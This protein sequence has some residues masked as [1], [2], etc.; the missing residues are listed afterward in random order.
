MAVSPSPNPNLSP[1][2]N[3]NPPTSRSVHLVW[4]PSFSDRFTVAG[5]RRHTDGEL[6]PE[7]DPNTVTLDVHLS[8]ELQTVRAHRLLSVSPRIP[9]S[10]Y[11]F[12]SLSRQPPIEERSSLPGRSFASCFRRAA[13]QGFALELAVITCLYA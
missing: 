13:A 7:I 9:S 3:P 1:N 11:P 4:R 12:L 2:P 6:P 5:A 10:S 8:R